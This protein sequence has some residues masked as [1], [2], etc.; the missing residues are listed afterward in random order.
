MIGLEEV[1]KLVKDCSLDD[2]TNILVVADALDDVGYGESLTSALRGMAR[3]LEE[4]NT[5][6][7]Q[8]IIFAQSDDADEPLQILND[9]GPAA[10]VDYLAQ[11]DNGDDGEVRDEMSAGSSDGT[12][13]VGE[14]L[15]TYNTRL[16]YIGLE[17]ILSGVSESQIEDALDDAYKWVDRKSKKSIRAKHYTS[18]FTR[19]RRATME[20]LWSS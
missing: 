17:R 12:E 11:W 3:D 4:G 15:L 5:Q 1:K 9:D 19:E 7:Y 8:E 18:G 20:S 10:A 6:K 16:G 14:Y 13:E 2:P